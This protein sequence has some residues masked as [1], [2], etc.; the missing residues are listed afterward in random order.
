VNN[1]QDL[2]MATTVKEYG[3]IDKFGVRIVVND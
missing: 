1:E 2:S 3:L